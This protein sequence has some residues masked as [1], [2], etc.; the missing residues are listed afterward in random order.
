MRDKNYSS[1]KEKKILEEYPQKIEKM[2]K[3]IE[4]LQ[5]CLANPECY[6]KRGI[7]SLSEE[8][9]ELQKKYDEM[10]DIFLEIEEK[11]EELRNI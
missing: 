8:L 2:E 9:E 6:E 7:V 5:H 11:A 3:Q 4:E 10:V 1:C